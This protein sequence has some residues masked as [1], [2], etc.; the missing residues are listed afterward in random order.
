MGVRAVRFKAPNESVMDYRPLSPLTFDVATAVQRAYFAPLYLGLDALSLERPALWVGNHTM[1]ALLDVPIMSRELH[2]RGAKLRLLGDRFHFK[3][4]GW[5]ALAKAWGGVEGSPDNCTALMQAGEHILV[6][7]GGAREVCRRKGEGELVWQQRTGFARMAIEHGYD[8]IPFASLGPN[9]AYDILLDAGDIT[10]S[11]LWR[12][13]S[14]VVP[15]NQLTRNGGLLLPVAKGLGPTAIP[16]PQR[17][18][19]GFGERIST[20][21][22]RGQSGSKEAQWAVREQVEKAIQGQFDYL[23]AYREKDRHYNWSEWRKKWA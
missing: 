4:P 5:R 20:D 19:F 8:I 6:F 17:Q 21:A 16:R 2:R 10:G 11:M 18:Y 23:R 9:D 3:I 12:S 7:P 13:L 14:K 15:I 22:F 1:Y